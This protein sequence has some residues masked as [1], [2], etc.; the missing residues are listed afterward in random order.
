MTTTP[1]LYDCEQRTEEWRELR[2]GK[3][4]ASR[5][6]D[7]LAKIKEGEA[8]TRKKYKAEIVCEI[9]T[10]LAV[11][12]F[13]S[14][15]MQWGTDTEPFA[16]A[17]YELQQDV[18]V[19]TVGF[20]THPTIKRFGCSPDGLVGSDG[21]VE[22]KCPN[23]STHIEYLLAGVVPAEYQPQM[24][25]AMACTGRQ[26]VDLVSY[27]PRLPSHLQLFCRRFPRDEARIAEIEAKVVKFLEEV[28]DVLVRLSSTGD[29][30]ML[31][32]ESLAQVQA[33]K[34]PQPAIHLLDAIPEVEANL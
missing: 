14:K 12:G 18:L 20:A 5:I 7:V 15:E 8:A 3:V 34:G 29:L 28:D 9:L 21:L 33:Q 23:T 24:L 10:G 11:E 2:L 13:K 1:I 19:Q 4:T 30:E 26:W 32:Q 22:I 27:D 31:L 25:V 16:R 17:A 6:S